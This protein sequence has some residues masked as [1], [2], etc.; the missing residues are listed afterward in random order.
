MRKWLRTY[1]SILSVDGMWTAVRPLESSGFSLNFADLSSLRWRHPSLRLK[2]GSAR[3]DG[4][5]WKNRLTRQI[6]DLHVIRPQQFPSRVIQS[7]DRELIS[8]LRLQ[9]SLFRCRLLSLRFQYQEDG[10]LP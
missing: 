4:N 8:H 1:L 5:E 2:N 3:D 6:L 10:A 7:G 9:Q